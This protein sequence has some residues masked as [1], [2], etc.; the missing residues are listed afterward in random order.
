MR[1]LLQTNP[2]SITHP[3]EPLQ[4]SALASDAGDE[5]G[6]GPSAH[7]LTLVIAANSLAK[8]ALAGAIAKSCF[9]YRT[10]RLAVW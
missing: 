10:K 9:A 2:E 3:E 6:F 4:A 7:M 5:G 8:S 1:M